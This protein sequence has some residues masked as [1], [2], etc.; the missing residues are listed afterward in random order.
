MYYLLIHLSLLYIYH[1]WQLY[2]NIMPVNLLLKWGNGDT[3]NET[4]SILHC[5]SILGYVVCIQINW[6]EF[7]QYFH[8]ERIFLK[9]TIL[10][11]SSLN[12]QI[13]QYIF[14]EMSS[15]RFVLFNFLCTQEMTIKW[16]IYA[17]VVRRQNKTQICGLYINVTTFNSHLFPVRF[18]TEISP[19]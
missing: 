18:V 16:Q 15:F 6:N 7:S 8:W 1:V 12:I 19:T 4:K 3:M 14:S 17:S 10:C 2:L 5:S 13:L 9:V 11:I